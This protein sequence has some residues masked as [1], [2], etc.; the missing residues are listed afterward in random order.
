MSSPDEL[1]PIWRA[2]ANSHRRHML[3]LLRERP[4][5]TSELGVEFPDL[6]RYAVMQHLAV[7]EEADLVIATRQGRERINSL[8]AV[9]LQRIYERWVS[10]FEGAWASAL[11]ALKREMEQPATAASRPGKPKPRRTRKRTQSREETDA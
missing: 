7:L 6:S 10:R 5:T 8:N 9:P 11:L 1:D 3:D 2:L 4:R